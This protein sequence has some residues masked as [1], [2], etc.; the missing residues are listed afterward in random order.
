MTKREDNASGHYNVRHA[1]V[2]RSRGAVSQARGPLRQ[3][4]DR[5]HFG[6]QPPYAPTFYQRLLTA[7]VKGSVSFRVK[8]PSWVRNDAWPRRHDIQTGPDDAALVADEV[9]KNL[10][11]LEETRLQQELVVSSEGAHC[12]VSPWLERTRW[13]HYLRGMSLNE[14]AKLIRLPHRHEEPV[15]DEIGSAIDRIVEAAHDSLCA[16]KV[17]FFG[18]KRIT[19][20]LPRKEVYSRP[21]VYK[22]QKSTYRQYKQ[23]WTSTRFGSGQ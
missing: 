6:E 7:G 10:A 1:P 23:S 19:S 11:A 12:Q 15:I 16:E 21:I 17:N 3:R 4:L 5:E 14:A 9:L 20:F 8:K 13:L 18:Q 22:L 2:R